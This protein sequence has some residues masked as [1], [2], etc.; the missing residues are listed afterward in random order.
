MVTDI[1]DAPGYCERDDVQE[2]LQE[3][4]Q[5][6]GSTPLGSTNVNAAIIGA[7][8]WFRRRSKAHFYD[9]TAQSSDIISDS[10]LQATDIRLS[11]PSS[12]HPQKGQLF[13]NSE[14]VNRQVEY[15]LTKVGPY[16]RVS[17]PQNHVESIDVL[18]VRDFGGDVE[19]WVAASDKTQ[20]RGEDYYLQVDGNT[21]YGRSYLYIF[22]EALPGLSSYDDVLLVDLSYGLDWQDDEWAG[23]RRGVAHLAAAELVSDDDVLTQIPDSGAIANVDTQAQQHLSAAMDRYLGGYLEVPIA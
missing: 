8:R 9:S 16:S 4:G 1:T 5:A 7:S 2:A 11:I 19:D 23:V 10:A 6:F 12:P 20:G 14:G 3:T 22:A 21:S 15:P 17:L 18:D 13:V